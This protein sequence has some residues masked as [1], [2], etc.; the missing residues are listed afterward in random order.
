MPIKV[1]NKRTKEQ[2]NKMHNNIIINM[3]NAPCAA[4]TQCILVGFAP[5]TCTIC[6]VKAAIATPTP[7]QSTA[8]AAAI[9]TTSPE[10]PQHQHH[11][12]KERT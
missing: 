11:N 8:T 10:Q 7:A 4:G 5:D 3:P 12:A 9:T 6:G 1:K 2:Q